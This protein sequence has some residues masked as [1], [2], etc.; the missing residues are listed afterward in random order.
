MGSWD[1]VPIYGKNL[2]KNRT[3]RPISLYVG[4]SSASTT[5]VVQNP[6]F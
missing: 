6:G 5:K 2:K 3:N 4:L 1:H